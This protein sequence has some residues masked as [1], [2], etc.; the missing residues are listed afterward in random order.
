MGE[1][2]TWDNSSLPR[3]V[4][5]IPSAIQGRLFVEDDGFFK[6]VIERSGVKEEVEGEEDVLRFVREKKREQATRMKKASPGKKKG[7]PSDP[8]PQQQAGDNAVPMVSSDQD[9]ESDVKGVS[10]ADL[11]VD[12]SIEATDS[13]GFDFTPRSLPPVATPLTARPLDVA[14]K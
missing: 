2:T 1:F 9:R 4:P 6:S 3:S 5:P 14:Y 8:R 11:A 12:M 13:D 7:P 10:S